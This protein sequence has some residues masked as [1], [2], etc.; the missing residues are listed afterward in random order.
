MGTA[1]E[2]LDAVKRERGAWV[3]RRQCVPGL[4]DPSHT[5]TPCGRG[6]HLTETPPEACVSSTA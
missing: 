2:M 3:T 1:Q 5:G 4:T 6:L